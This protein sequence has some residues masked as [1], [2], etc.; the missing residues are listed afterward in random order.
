M[1][2]KMP[3]TAPMG[4]KGSTLNARIS[5]EMR[6]ALDAEAERTGQSVSEIAARW[7]ARGRAL[8]RT[9]AGVE[10][11][12]KMIVAFANSIEAE[13]VGDPFEDLLARDVL[14]AG[15]HQLVDLALPFTPNTPEGLE[16]LDL[17]SRVGVHCK[18]VAVVVSNVPSASV[19]KGVP[20]L[21]ADWT[22]LSFPGDGN[23][24]GQMLVE[25]P[26]LAQ[27]LERASQAPD[28][29]HV[30]RQLHSYAREAARE[31]PELGPIIEPLIAA[32]SELD[33]ATAAYMKDRRTAAE[34]GV[35]L[36]R[37]FAG[38]RPLPRE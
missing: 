27:L 20:V 25:R 38:V 26:T 35:R 34:K 3:R 7:L 8:G 15:L 1:D 11:L 13:G 17:Q 6:D 29:Q 22:A 21:Q 19:A 23:A 5:G 30:R 2:Q 28:D 32:I 36:A 24:V 37:T 18:I 14:Q 4:G 33:A 31:L 9:G 10:D 16:V 12:L